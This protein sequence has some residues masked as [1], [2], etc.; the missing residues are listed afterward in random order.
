MQLRTLGLVV[1]GGKPRAVEAAGIARE[2][3]ARCGVTCA[4]IDVWSGDGRLS[5]VLA[6]RHEIDER[7]TLTMCASRPLAIPPGIEALL[8]YGRGPA[9]PAPQVRPRVDGDPDAGVPLQVHA[10]ND[11][12]F[13]KL[14]RDRQAS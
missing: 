7:L 5:A 4:E 2:W 12:V 1:H 8:R 10:L 3:A 14:A 9:L 13:E 6:D 11:V